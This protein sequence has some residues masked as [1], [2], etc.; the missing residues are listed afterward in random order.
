MKKLYVGNLSLTTTPEEVRRLFA[1]FGRVERVNI[2]RDREARRSRGFGFVEMAAEPAA[3]RA[4]ATLNGKEFAGR[5]LRVHEAHA[6]AAQPQRPDTRVLRF[7]DSGH[8]EGAPRNVSQWA[9]AV[10]TAMNAA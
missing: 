7:D 9:R 4:A 1:V 10:R 8:F 3:Q 2:V 6:T 5:T